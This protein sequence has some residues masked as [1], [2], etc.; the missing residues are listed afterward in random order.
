MLAIQGE[1]RT[2]S[3]LAGLKANA[4]ILQNNIATMKAVNAG[5]LPFG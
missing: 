2:S 5:K 4:R 1:T 3:W